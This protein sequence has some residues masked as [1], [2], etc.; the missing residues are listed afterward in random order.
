VTTDAFPTVRILVVDDETDMLHICADVL[1][2]G[3][4]FSEDEPQVET[5]STASRAR[6][7][8][9]RQ[10]FGLIL[11]D[12]KMPRVAGLELMHFAL[13]H[14]RGAAVVLMTAYPCYG[15]AVLA[16]K[17]GAFDYVIKPFTAGQLREVARKALKDKFSRSAVGLSTDAAEGGEPLDRFIGQSSKMSELRRLLEKIS[18]LGENVLLLGETGTGKGLVAQI[19][20]DRGPLRRRPM[21]TLD[22]GAIPS[23][24]MES[25][26]FGHEK[27][28]FTGADRV[29]KGLLELAEDGTLFLDEVSELPL[30]LQSR[31]LRA[32]QEREFRRM[33]AA[34]VRRVR[35]RVLAASNRDLQ[36]EV[37][38]E[39][40]REDLYYR[41]N[42]I[43]VVLPPLRDHPEDV[44]HLADVFIARFRQAHSAQMVQDISSA[45]R[46]KLLRYRWPGNVRELENVIRRACALCGSRHIEVDDL[47][48]EIL[49]DHLPQG[50][51]QPEGFFRSRHHWLS[52]FE[53]RYFRD[54]LKQSAGNVVEAARMSGIPRPTLYRYLRKY[55]LDP[56]QFRVSP[57]RERL[58]SETGTEPAAK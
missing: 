19:I 49:T 40:F 51:T 52:R 8:L 45:A 39:R 17:E 32:L 57:A 14:G 26:L 34:E 22:C 33:G 13:E 58:D 5:A 43:P 54:L 15:D 16:T 44:P 56:A 20:H 24:L 10:E 41:L 36:Q 2:S 38:E 29:R 4:G 21:V 42:V 46:D 12:V 28:S 25:E 11:L 23:E 7:L 48:E 35:A 27:G 50:K 1:R 47:P 18:S 30:H 55:S 53:K 37:R 6:Q 9:I 31:L 3:L